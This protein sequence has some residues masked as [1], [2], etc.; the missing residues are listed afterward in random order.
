MFLSKFNSLATILII[1]SSQVALASTK[2]IPFKD[3]LKEYQTK[4]SKILSAQQGVAQAEFQKIRQTDNWKGQ[5]N[6]NPELNFETRV[7]EVV[8]TQ[9]VSNRAQKMSASYTQSA[10]SGTSLTLSGVEFVEKS[11][12]LV[13]SLDSVYSAKITQDLVRNSFGRTQRSQAKKAKTDYHVAMMDYRQ[14][15]VNSCQDAFTLYA[16]TYIQQEKWAVLA[17]QMRDARKAQKLTKRLYRDRLIHKVDFLASES[18]FLQT[19]TQMDQ[20]QQLLLNNKRQMMAYFS[21]ND[22]SQINLSDPS[23]FLGALPTPQNTLTFTEKMAQEKLKSQ[24]FEVDRAKS[25]RWTDVQLGLEAGQRK[26]RLSFSNTLTPFNEDYLYASLN[27]SFDIINNTEN[28]ALKS[29]IDVK[30]SLTIQN[31]IIGK[32]QRSLVNN[33]LENNDLLKQ[34]VS[35]SERQVKILNQKANI[36][37][38]QMKRGK[39]DF[40]NYLIH[41]NAYRSQQINSLNLK[42]DLWL[43]HFS[44]K[45]EFTNEQDSFCKGES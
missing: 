21:N 8:P 44:L 28:S 41:R 2:T 33:L 23:H 37:F 39:M 14:S 45:R 3:F 5:L 29:A 19:K 4:S 6:I 1:G 40:Q 43:N 42:K 13:S 24:E 12:P 15:E 26:G 11:N 31:K 30:N 35:T 22:I 9:T 34:L 20:A 25:D 27:V 7:T 18:D 38:Q 17:E 32:T 36:A 16:D 10:P